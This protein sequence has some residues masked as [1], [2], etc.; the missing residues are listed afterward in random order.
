MKLSPATQSLYTGKHLLGFSGGVDSVA[1]FFLLL[2]AN[3]PF[4]IAIVHYHTRK[5]ADDEVAYAQE[6]AQIHNKQCFV[7]HAPQFSHNFETQARIFRFG[8]FDEIIESYG[9]ESLILAHQ[10]NDR[11][12]WFMMQLTLGSGL[13]NLLGFDWG[14][15]YPIVRPL[16]S[17]PKEELYRFCKEH[18]LRYFEDTSNADL[19]FRRN[20][21]RHRF[22]NDLVNT[23][24]VGIAQSLNYLAQDKEYLLSQIAPRILF[25][26]SLHKF[27]SEARESLYKDSKNICEFSKTMRTE[28]GK[29]QCAIFAFNINEEYLLLLACDKA[30][31]LCGYVL[32]SK[33]REEIVKSHFNC[34][35][36]N[37]IIAKNDK[38]L[39]IALDSISMFQIVTKEPMTK[40]FK[41][42]CATYHIPPKIRKLI[43]WEFQ[44]I[45][46]H[47][48]SGA[49]SINNPLPSHKTQQENDSF[50]C[51]IKNFFTL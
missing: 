41:T 43:W 20:F 40:P 49:D 15:T 17:T 10:L 13:G 8:F 21:F 18:D 39:F 27:V 7:A 33:Q 24:G 22:C 28:R 50:E 44:A 46:T 12:E 16:E 37:L 11:F 3:V 30:A 36:H 14:R 23:F 35:I 47:I 34:K 19:R 45:S 32:S 2:E 25:L 26:E 31:K 1:L 29:Y 48:E 9:Y 51:K 6:L 4:D 42:L 5:E 38:L